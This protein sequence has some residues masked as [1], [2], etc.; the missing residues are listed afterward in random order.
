[1]SRRLRRILVTA[2]CTAA[3]L[4]PGVSAY[5]AWT[6]TATATGTVSLL[7][8]APAA[9]TGF[10]CPTSTPTDVT[11]SWV[12]AQ[13]TTGYQLLAQDG[14]VLAELPGTSTTVTVASQQI[15]GN[16]WVTV[17]LRAVNADGW[18][19]STAQVHVKNKEVSCR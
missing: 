17:T 6:A 5:A 9:P 12:A 18:A 2:A 8:A 13:D 10:T 7:P 16:G 4:V 1:M 11:F 14:S 19:D 3:L 15:T